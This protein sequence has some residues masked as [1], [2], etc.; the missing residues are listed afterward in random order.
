MKQHGEGAID[1]RAG[2]DGAAVGRLRVTMA[3]CIR[4]RDTFRFLFHTAHGCLFSIA[5]I[6]PSA[7][8]SAA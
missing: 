2:A 6:V 3:S 7:S 1:L 8:P 4:F 5:I